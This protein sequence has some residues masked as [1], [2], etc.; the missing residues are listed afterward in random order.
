M[1][2]IFALVLLVSA[3]PAL[4]DLNIA[5][6]PT[7]TTNTVVTGGLPP[8]NVTHATQFALCLTANMAP[9]QSDTNLLWL[10][11]TITCV[12]SNSLDQVTWFADPARSFAFDV[13]TNGI[14]ALQTNFTG[15]GAV[16]FERYTVTVSN[17]VDMTW[18][19][20]VKP[21]L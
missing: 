21:G 16:N 11:C 8:V 3:L 17:N 9:T 15:M 4:A 13:P 14:A 7:T 6:C 1:K 19:T 10:P 5:D 2:Q 12:A 20:S 18:T